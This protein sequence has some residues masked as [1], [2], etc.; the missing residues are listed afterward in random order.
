MLL[1]PLFTIFM[2]WGLSQWTIYTKSHGLLIFLKSVFFSDWRVRHA[3]DA[4]EEREGKWCQ[5]FSSATFVKGIIAEVVPPIVQE[6]VLTIGENLDDSL[7]SWSSLEMD[8]PA[9]LPP[10]VL[11]REG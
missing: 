5:K 8:E 4:K 10:P 1:G 3:L 6:P 11:V 7:G 2:A 9:P